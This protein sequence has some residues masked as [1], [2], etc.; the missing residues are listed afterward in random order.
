[1][2]INGNKTNDNNMTNMNVQAG[3]GSLDAATLRSLAD[4]LL[5]GG[6]QPGGGTQAVDLAQSLLQSNP[7]ADGLVRQLAQMQ[8][9]NQQ[10]N[11]QQ[12]VVNN[13]NSNNNII[14]NNNNNNAFQLGTCRT[15]LVFPKQ[16]V[17]HRSR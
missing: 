12:Q 7:S 17:L 5:S 9:Q 11:Y 6:P 10:V 1:M 13:N 16:S 15:S 4:A 3:G 2:L 8:M 14:N